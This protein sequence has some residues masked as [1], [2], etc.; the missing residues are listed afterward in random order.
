VPGYS[1]QSP[2]GTKYGDEPILLYGHFYHTIRHMTKTTIELDEQKLLRVMDLT[3]IKTRKEA[4]DYALVQAERAA[5]LAKLLVK[6]WTREDLE[7]ALDPAY[8]IVTLRRR[9][10]PRKSDAD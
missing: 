2:S 1:R 9:D 8:D 4:V 10:K 5:K 7:S 6:S 3:G